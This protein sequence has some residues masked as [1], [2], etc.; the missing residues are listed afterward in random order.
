VRPLLDKAMDLTSPEAVERRVL[1][2]VNPSARSPEDK[3][4]TRNI[5]AALQILLPGESARPHRHSMNALRFVLEGRGA[6][7]VVNGKPCPMEEGDLILTPAWTWHEHVHRGEKPIIWLDT[8]DVP[9]HLYMGTARF[10]PGPVTDLPAT[11]SDDVSPTRTSCRMS[12]QASKAIRR[13]SAIL[14]QPRRRR[15]SRRRSRATALGV[16][17]ISIR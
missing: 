4:T 2:L 7:T 1:S 8:L 13:Y 11:L 12:A 17:V 14:M 6:I 3:A 16:C 5:S 15:S 9:L 10:Q